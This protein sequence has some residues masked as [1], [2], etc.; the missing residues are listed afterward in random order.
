MILKYLK[1]TIKNVMVFIETIVLLHI[2]IVAK[3]MFN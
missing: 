3:C 1:I 2:N